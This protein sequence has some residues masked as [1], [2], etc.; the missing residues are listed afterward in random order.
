MGM[1]RTLLNDRGKYKKYESDSGNLSFESPNRVVSI[2]HSGNWC[3]SCQSPESVP[4][5][6]R[7]VYAFQ[8]GYQSREMAMERA[9]QYATKPLSEF[10]TS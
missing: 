9:K 8:G 10:D 3:V 5:A 2:F 4:T 1:G 7:V 6:D